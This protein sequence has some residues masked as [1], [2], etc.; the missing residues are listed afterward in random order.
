MPFVMVPEPGTVVPAYACDTISPVIG[1][2][3]RRL[4]A[5]HTWL[6]GT[7]VKQYGKKSIGACE[8]LYRL[9]SKAEFMSLDSYTAPA[10]VTRSP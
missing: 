5:E 2:L 7:P 3:A 1:F 10:C 6:P 4:A 9:G 8:L